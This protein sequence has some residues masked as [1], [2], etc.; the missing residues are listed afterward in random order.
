MNTGKPS[1]GG[2]KAARC[3]KVDW[4]PPGTWHLAVGNSEA[5]NL[6][7]HPNTNMNIGKPSHLHKEDK[8]L[9]HKVAW[10]PPG[11]WQSVICLQ[12][13]GQCKVSPYHKCMYTGGGEGGA[14]WLTG[15][16]G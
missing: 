10:V 2:E 5:S 1:Q 9:C 3:S 13:S 12:Y 7:Y 11:T 8:K 6:K 15:R 4:V 14:A 16:V